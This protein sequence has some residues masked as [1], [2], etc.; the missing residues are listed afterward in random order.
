VTVAE[1][2]PDP[3]DY[4]GAKEEMLV[5]ASAVFVQPDHPVSLDNPYNWWTYV[6]GAD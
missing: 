5:P 1:H 2:R 4:P 3:A 6:P